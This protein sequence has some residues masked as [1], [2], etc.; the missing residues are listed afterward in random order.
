MLANQLKALPVEKQLVML[1]EMKTVF[2]NAKNPWNGGPTFDSR[3][4]AISYW[5][6]LF[7]G[8]LAA[9]YTPPAGFE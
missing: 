7:E 4:Q 5:Q 9:G 6:E 2:V 1:E 3:E 8:L